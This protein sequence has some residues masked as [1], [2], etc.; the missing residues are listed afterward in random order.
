MRT[1]TDTQMVIRLKPEHLGDLTLRVAVG[2]DGAVQASFH[3]DNAH[4]RSV[5]EHSLVQ[6]RQE[7]SNQ[8]IKVDRVGVYTGLADGQMPQGQGQD[9]WQQGSQ[10]RGET[11]NYAR[12]DADNYIEG[13]EESTP[14]AVQTSGGIAGANG[15]DYRV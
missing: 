11:R 1:L 7:L 5:I 4:V 3:S 8:G 9:A 14:V 6:L 12:G 13:I 15:V 2:S 10:S